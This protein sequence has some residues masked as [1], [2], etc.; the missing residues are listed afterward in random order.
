MMPYNKPYYAAL[1]EAEG[2]EKVQD[3]YA[4]Y[5]EAGMLNMLDPN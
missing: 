2:F 1:I 4:Y 3:L 5:A